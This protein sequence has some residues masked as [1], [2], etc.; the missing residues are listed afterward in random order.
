M[1][2]NCFADILKK[3]VGVHTAR[4]VKC[5]NRVRSLRQRSNSEVHETDREEISLAIET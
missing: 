5:R 1:L 4:F 2:K 3:T